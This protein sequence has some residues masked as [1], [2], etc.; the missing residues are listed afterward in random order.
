MSGE[1]PAGLSL[2]SRRRTLAV[3]GGGLLAAGF[4]PAAAAAAR[5]DRRFKVYRQG[6]A[7]GSHTVRFG[8]ADGG[9]RV[10]S[11]LDLAVKV[12]FVT[13]FHYRQTAE[14]LWRGGVLV[15]SRI[16]TDD[17]GRKTRIVVERRDGKLAVEGRH[18]GYSVDLGAMTDL[19]FWHEGITRQRY[20]IDGKDGELTRIATGPGVEETIRVGDAIIAAR[21]FTIKVSEKR[22]GTIWYDAAGNWVKARL[23]TRGETLDYELVV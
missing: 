4:G 6:T 5:P 11:R 16:E 21:R 7:I 15:Q 9:M 22:S 23:N 20:L 12:A 2:H 19:C 17:D 3:I 14:D 13:L 10:A 1:I 8:A 18:G